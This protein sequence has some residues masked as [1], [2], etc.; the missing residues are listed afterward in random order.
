LSHVITAESVGEVDGTRSFPDVGIAITYAKIVSVC[1][2]IGAI[3][4]NV[5]MSCT[6]FSSS[7]NISR[8]NIARLEIL[9]QHA[10]SEVK[11]LAPLILEVARVKPHK[12]RRWK[13]L[14]QNHSDLSSFCT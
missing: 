11:D 3:A 7:S 2:V 13:F 1:R 5:W 12:R 9:V 8:K 4:S 6:A 14:A 10:T